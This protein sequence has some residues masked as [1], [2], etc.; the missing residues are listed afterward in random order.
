MKERLK[1][2]SRDSVIRFSVIFSLVFIFLETVLILVFFGKLPPFI[3]FFNSM[4]W[5]ESRLAPPNNFLYLFSSFIAVVI[6]D[7]FLSAVFYKSYPLISRILSVTSLLFVFLGFL[8]SVQIF[9]LVF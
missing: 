6:L 3:P 5:G 1:N 4:P 9:I 8:A 7:N 2:A